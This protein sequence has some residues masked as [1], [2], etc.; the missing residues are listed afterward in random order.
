LREGSWRFALPLLAP[1]FL[2]IGTHVPTHWETRYTIPAFSSY[3]LLA[4]WA[5][6]WAHSKRRSRRT[7]PS[8]T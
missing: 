4:G 1:A 5:V 2:V 3:I 7:R 8:E 6:V